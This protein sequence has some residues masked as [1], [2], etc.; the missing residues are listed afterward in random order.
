MK[1]KALLISV[2]LLLPACGPDWGD[3]LSCRP[4]EDSAE[5]SDGQQIPEDTNVTV[6]VNVN[7]NQDQNQTQTQ[8]QS[9]PPAPAPVVDAGTPD[10]GQTCRRV[11]TCVSRNYTCGKH[12]KHNH[13]CKKQDKCLKEVVK[14]S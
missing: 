2:A 14:C 7:V 9:Q 12:H 8:T 1:L 6:I 3:C 13:S 5:A 10:A 4:G 11:C